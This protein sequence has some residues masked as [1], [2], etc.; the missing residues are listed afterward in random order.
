MYC[1]GKRR[2]ISL[3]WLLFYDVLGATSDS[4]LVSVVSSVGTAASTF[5]SK[6]RGASK[7][8]CL[9][10]FFPFLQK[11][12]SAILTISFNEPQSNMIRQLFGP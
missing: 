8:S 1:Y 6:L 12:K 4:V 5:G 2:K 3:L 7:I 11:V 10:F 9:L